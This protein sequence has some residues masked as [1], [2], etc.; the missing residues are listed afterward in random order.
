MVGLRVLGPEFCAIFFYLVIIPNYI[1]YVLHIFRS[2]VKDVFKT[3][4]FF[5]VHAYF[6]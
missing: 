3:S 1:L 4:E 6:L 5:K 2:Y